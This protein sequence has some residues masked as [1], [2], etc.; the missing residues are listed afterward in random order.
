MWLERRKWL[1]QAQRDGL[2]QRI[3]AMAELIIAGN[4]FPFWH[5][6]VAA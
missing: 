2:D 3:V 4:E 1:T 6:P 5:Y